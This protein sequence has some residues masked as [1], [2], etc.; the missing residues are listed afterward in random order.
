MGVVSDRFL[1]WCEL[2][3]ESILKRLKEALCKTSH[4]SG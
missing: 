4:I 3:T 1:A 2:L